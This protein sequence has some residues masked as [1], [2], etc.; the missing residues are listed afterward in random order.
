MSSKDSSSDN[1]AGA[2]HGTE[3]KLQLGASAA[4]SLSPAFQY[5]LGL[6]SRSRPLAHRNELQLELSLSQQKEA[7]LPPSM[8]EG[9]N[10]VLLPDLAI[11][12]WQ[13]VHIGKQHI[14]GGLETIFCVC[15]F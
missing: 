14:E 8:E 2:P 11:K 3:I 12:H 1:N 15:I 13:H 4:K 5:P 6:H 10:R 9:L 7:K